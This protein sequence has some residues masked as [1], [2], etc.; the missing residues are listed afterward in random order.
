MDQNAAE[1]NK[2]LADCLRKLADRIEG[3]E[4]LLCS[5]ISTKIPDPVAALPG[6]ELVWQRPCP[7]NL[8]IVIGDE[9]FVSKESR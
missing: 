2:R 5:S 6:G 8:V 1:S 9:E 3:R 4:E 7:I